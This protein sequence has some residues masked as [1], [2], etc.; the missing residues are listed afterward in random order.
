[1]INIKLENKLVDLAK[2]LG[3]KYIKP[4]NEQWTP[5]DIIFRDALNNGTFN[6]CKPV[7]KSTCIEWIKKYLENPEM[8][9]DYISE[10]AV[11]NSGFLLWNTYQGL[12]DDLE[13]F[14]KE[15]NK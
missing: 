14:L 5:L 15:E 3:L 9:K 10:V 8:Y 11:N 4:N 13:I 1:M 2:K 6:F 12:Q 7:R